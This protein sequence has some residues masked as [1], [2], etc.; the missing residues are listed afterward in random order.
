M[1]ASQSPIRIGLLLDHS[2]PPCWIHSFVAELLR[3]KQVEVVALVI[4]E[5]E[6]SARAMPLLLRVWTRLERFWIGKSDATLPRKIH[7]FEIEVLHLAT[8]GHKRTQQNDAFARLRQLDLDVLVDLGTF[9]VPSECVGIA[10]YGVW[11]I[12]H[13]QSKEKD[14]VLALLTCLDSG[15]PACELA[16]HANTSSGGYLLYRST[17]QNHKLSLYRNV[18]LDR[19]RRTQIFLRRLVDL[20]ERG[21]ESVALEPI[22]LKKE[23]GNEFRLTTGVLFL[24]RW[25]ARHWREAVAKF[26]YE[27]QWIIRIS[28]EP[29]S[30]EAPNLSDAKELAILKPPR[31]QNYADPFLFAKNG[32]TYL[33]FENWRT[34]DDGKIWCTELGSEGA[35]LGEAREVLAR[36]YHLSYPFVFA[37]QGETYLLPETAQN[38]TVEIYRAVDFPWI[39]EPAGVLLSNVS[40]VDPTILHH[41]GKLWLFVAGLGG[42]ATTY[43][44]LSLFFSDSLLGPWRPHPKNPVVCDVHRARPAGEIVHEDGILIRPGQDCSRRYGYAITLNR[45]EVLSETDYRERPCTT[46]HPD[47]L[48]GIQATHTLNR[49]AGLQVLDAKARSPRYRFLSKSSLQ[50]LEP[51]HSQIA[52]HQNWSATAPANHGD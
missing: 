13:A 24:S 12:R 4:A 51:A 20:F 5:P 17:F 11:S 1:T 36:D 30:H 41:D 23:E 10:S 21:W 14:P 2:K 47:W 19:Q 42:S 6:R 48:K 27:E 25:I 8:D 35:I 31:G 16:L 3:T 33:F 49:K 18:V 37:W 40:A 38:K 9:E 7:E 39:W 44:E 52:G 50:R 26:W 29:I 15:A 34:G 45:I 46:I 32:R 22:N 43:S 28:D